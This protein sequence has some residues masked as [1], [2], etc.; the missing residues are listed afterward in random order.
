MV[1]HLRQ[2]P[3]DTY[4][5]LREVVIENIRDAILSG[6]FPAGMRLTELQLA[7]EMG[8]SRTPIREAIR[9]LEQEGLVVMIPRRG[10][11]VADV[12]IHDINEVYEIRTALETLAA[13]LAAERIEDSEIEE[14]DK[15]LIATRTYVSRLDYTKIVEMDTAFHDVIYKASRNKRCM[16]II[17]SGSRSQAS[18]NGVCLT[19]GVLMKCFWNTGLLWMPLPSG[20]WK[21][22]RWPSRPIWKMRNG[23]CSASLKNSTWYQQRNTNHKK[24]KSASHASESRGDLMARVKRLERI[25]A[26]TKE[27]TDKPFQLF[28]FSYFC[29]KFTVAKSTLSEDV[30]TV[31]N[32]LAA[33]DLGIIETVAGAS[34]GVRFIPYHTAKSDNQFL[35]ELCERLNSPD[36]VLPGG[37]IYM[38]D[39]I[40]NPQIVSRLGEII[41]QRSIELKPQYIMTVET[42]G[43]PLGLSAA[44][45]FNIPMVMARKEAR[46]TE[47]PAVSISYLS[48]STKK[49]QSMSLPKKALPHGARVLVIDD[50]MRAGGTANG[51]CELAEEVGAEVVGVYLFIAAKE[52]AK[53]LVRE[54][55]SLLTLRGVD[56]TSKAVDIVP[57]ML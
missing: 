51:L 19:R 43:I 9:N 3:L 8:V 50:F 54:Y 22:P 26:L 7:D 17:T 31:R 4:K 27:L 35:G 14:M 15:Y 47:G 42:K 13:G 20:T 38:N 10:A 44:K 57:E 40:L 1:K 2:I 21:K 6:D 49:I 36:R 24:E 32:G 48:G 41:M 39:L 55:A 18:A 28:P 30:Q 46:I 53:K 52:P 23:P 37:M 34:G 16:N 12:S 5:P 29:D 11:Y 33:Y 56:E 25:V 45:A